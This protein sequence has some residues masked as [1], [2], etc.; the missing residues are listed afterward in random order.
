[1]TMAR[2]VNQVFT[3]QHGFISFCHSR[4][5][6]EGGGSTF[7]AAKPILNNAYVAKRENNNGK[8]HFSPLPNL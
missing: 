7:T 3:S 4:L 1:M 8:F 2:M 6:E 5:E